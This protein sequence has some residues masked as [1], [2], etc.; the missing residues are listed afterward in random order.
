MTRGMKSEQ[1]EKSFTKREGA[2]LRGQVPR[3]PHGA[4][5]CLCDS[6]RPSSSL[7]LSLPLSLS[8]GR[9]IRV[10]PSISCLFCGRGFLKGG[11]GARCE[12]PGGAVFF[13][14]STHCAALTWL[15][16]PGFVIAEGTSPFIRSAPISTH[17]RT[18]LPGAL[19][20][21]PYGWLLA[22]SASP[23]SNYIVALQSR[24]CSP[25]LE[26]WNTSTQGATLKSS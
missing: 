4:L 11:A 12:W 19:A 23:G 20:P 25:S 10:P 16:S 6:P 15:L 5:F 26:P 8:A 24:F 9:S 17:A 21:V 22:I 1:D 2:L 18:L 13:F 14:W 3:K 7:S